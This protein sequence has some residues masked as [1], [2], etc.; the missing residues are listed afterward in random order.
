MA[1]P[2]RMT[3]PRPY[4]TL[5]VGQPSH[6]HRDLPTKLRIPKPQCRYNRGPAAAAA[7][8]R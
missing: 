5:Q 4:L 7:S 1:T 6:E 2:K 8:S 3:H